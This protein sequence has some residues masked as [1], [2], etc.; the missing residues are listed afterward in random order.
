MD[1]SFTFSVSG[2][3]LSG[4]PNSLGI[5]MEV[6]STHVTLSLGMEL[7]TETESSSALVACQHN[8]LVVLVSSLVMSM[9]SR[10]MSPNMVSNRSMKCWVL[11]PAQVT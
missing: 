8:S 4:I 5:R 2:K 9:S 10:S 6:M 11:V 7:C 3:L 1:L